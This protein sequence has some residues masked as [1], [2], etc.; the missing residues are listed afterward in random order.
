MADEPTR[1]DSEHS[2]KLNKMQQLTIKKLH[3][4]CKGLIGLFM[5]LVDFD[6]SLKMSLFSQSFRIEW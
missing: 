4:K 2:L 5:M 6:S 3:R 1:L